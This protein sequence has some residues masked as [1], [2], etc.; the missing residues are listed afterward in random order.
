MKANVSAALLIKIMVFS[1]ELNSETCKEVTGEVIK[2][3][4]ALDE[5][6][7]VSKREL[8]GLCELI[9]NS[10]NRYITFYGNRNFLISGEMYEDGV[11]LTESML[12]D[13]NKSA[14]KNS[15][16]EIE[17]CAVFSYSPSKLKTEITLYMF[18]DPLCPFCNRIGGEIKDLSDRLGFK[19]KVLLLNVHGEKGREKCIE[20]VCRNSV[21]PAFNFIEYNKA[22]WKKTDTKKEFICPIGIELVDKTEKLSEKLGIDSVPFFFINDGRHV[23]GAS[24]EDVELLFKSGE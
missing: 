6:S 18:T 14:L 17:N 19:V 2:K 5:F 3:H 9:I 1:G 7:I 11:S 8:N 15:I 24:I 20:A 12:Y 4:L 16:S 21:N 10:D 23:S 13:V 22:E